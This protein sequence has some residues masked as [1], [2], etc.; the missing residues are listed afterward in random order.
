MLS[1][2]FRPWGHLNWILGK[3]DPLHW[4]FI[5]CI[6]TE[7]RCLTA[8]ELLLA[9][10]SIAHPLFVEI[11]DPPSAEGRIIAQK[12]SI[13]KRKLAY[14]GMSLEIQQ[15]ELLC[16][17]YEI[18]QLADSIT[19]RKP[20]NVIFD[21]TSFPKRYFFPLIKLLLQE[22]TIENLII[23]YTQ[24]DKYAASDLSDDPEP[25]YPLPLFRTIAHPEPDYELAF[26]GTGFMP[27]SLPKLLKDNHSEISLRL[28]FPFPPGPPNYQ[29][30]W[31]FIRKIEKHYTFKDQDHIVR[32]D[33]LDINSSYNYLKS[34]TEDGEKKCLF[35]PYGPKPISLAMCLFAIKHDAPVFYTQ[36]KY[37]SPDYS[38]GAKE[39][40]A[41]P[42]R[43]FGRDY[44][45]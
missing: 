30:S 26:V 31:E 18:V 12:I 16:A 45:Q 42:V 36:P 22:D 17:D 11:T 6:S 9:R 34:T 21:I 39:T 2:V 8:Y 19:A 32:V 33:A 14:G 7:D 44:F 29:R 23:T 28:F 37:Y 1:T 27:F 24:P 13:N 15:M 10:N 43:L 25:W 40:I 4:F 20:K 35:A 41:Y 3:V 38:T 5:G